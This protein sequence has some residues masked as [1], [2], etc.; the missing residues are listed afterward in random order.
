MKKWLLVLVGCLA[1]GVGL[2]AQG[3]LSQQVLQLLSRTN[4]WIGSNTFN[5][6]R[7]ANTAIPSDTTFRI[8]ADPSGNLYF[9]G[10]LI[11]G[12]GGG[13]T[14]H[15]LL[16]TTHPDTLAASPVRGSVLVS[17][18]TPKWAAVTIGTNGQVLQSNGTDTVFG[19]NGAALTNLNAGALAGTASAFDGNAITNLNATQLLTGTVPLARL[20]NIANAQIAAGAAIVYSKL[21]LTNSIVNADIVAAAGIPYSKLTL[22]GLIVN[23]DLAGTT[24]LFAKW[25]SNGCSATQ[26]PQYTGAAWACRTLTTADVTGAGTVTSVALSL[27]GGVF[28]VSGSPVTTTGTLTGTLASQSQNFFFAAPSGSAGAPTFRAIVSADYPTSGVAAG[29]Y[30]LVTVNN[31]GIVTAAS[32]SLAS[33]TITVST[34]W[35]FTQT[36]NQGATLF[37]GILENITDSASLAASTL[38]DLQVAAASKF[39]VTKAGNGVFAGS[40]TGTAITGTTGAFSSTVSMTALTATTG[41]FSGLLSANLGA[42]VAA[43]QTLAVTDIDKLTVGANIIPNTI[44]FTCTQLTETSV[45]G[46]CVFIADRAYTITGIKFVQ[47]AQ[48][49]AGCAADMEKLTGT[50]APGGGAVMGTGV[51]DC[52]ATANNTVTTYTL[53]GTPT[54]ASGNRMAIKLAGTLTALRGL[55]ATVQMKA[56]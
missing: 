4:T 30:P 18:S 34:P 45:S 36:W 52:N 41:A 21:S 31:K 5:N 55:T 15:N 8:Y 29:T 27:G 7:M 16:S 53:S 33:G 2:G 17:N 37:N 3:T 11:A 13:V 40:I 10:G 25:A 44:T 20:S 39:S 47:R 12:A 9:N 1:L 19:T 43:G 26:V 35:T 46:D 50:Q 22:T 14:P 54:L 6:F 48:G 32:A 51:Y 38:I 23:G 56:S 42:T 28:T 24:I 49:G